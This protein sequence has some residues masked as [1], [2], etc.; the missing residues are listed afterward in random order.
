[1]IVDKGMR[2]KVAAGCAYGW[3]A[4]LSEFVLRLPTSFFLGVLTDGVGYPQGP[5]TKTR[6]NQ[7]DARMTLAKQKGQRA[8]AFSFVCVSSL[9]K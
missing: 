9:F 4:H 2:R 7:C 6:P 1:M 5:R 3:T 8:N